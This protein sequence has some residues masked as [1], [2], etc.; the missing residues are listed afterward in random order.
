MSGA[1]PFRATPLDRK[2]AEPL[3]RQLATTLHNVIKNGDLLSDQGLPSEVELIDMFGVSRTVVR[4]ALAEL[5]RRGVIYKIRAK[6]SYVTPPSPDLRFIGS[7]IGSSAEL[8]AIGH[9][10]TTRILRQEGA[11]ATP[12]EAHALRLEPEVE[13]VHLRRLRIVDGAP[14][15]LVDTTLPR[16]LFPGLL[17]ANLENRSLYEHL[18][19]HYGAAPAGA[20]RW[21]QAIRPEPNVAAFLDIEPESPVLRI[22]SITWNRDE[23]PFELYTAYHRSDRSRFYVGI[24]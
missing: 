15:M 18:R 23:V 24:R 12:E 13:V 1:N 20:D 3:W 16:R 6:G 19:R 17:R 7:I 22:E 9:T 4:E 2:L 10:P 14:W 21:M 8:A 5:V 11:V